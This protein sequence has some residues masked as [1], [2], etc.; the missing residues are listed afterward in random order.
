MITSWVEIDQIHQLPP[1]E[2]EV[3]LGEFL[4]DPKHQALFDRIVDS[5]MGRYT[6]PVMYR[7]DIHAIVL[8]CAW[9]TICVGE[10]HKRARVRDSWSIALNYSAQDEVRKFTE[11]SDFVGSTGASGRVRR[12]RMLA[13]TRARMFDESGREPSVQSVVECHNARMAAERADPA[14]QGVLATVEDMVPLRGSYLDDN[15]DAALSNPSLGS[16]S[17]CPIVPAEATALIDRVIKRCSDGNMRQVAVA[18]YGR[19]MGS[20]PSIGTVSEAALET[21]LSV[22]TVRRHVLRINS[23]MRTVLRDEFG[24]T[25]ADIVLRDNI[26]PFGVSGRRRSTT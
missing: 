14:R 15:Q 25:V 10:A 9:Q 16:E 19:A 22:D 24:V 5:L 17:D 8:T 3:A 13:A 26:Q 4:R 6:I 20:P 21:G 18:V 7:D 23:L 11:S 2:Q 1:A 12:Y